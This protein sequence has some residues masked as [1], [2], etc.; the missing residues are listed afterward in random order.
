MRKG[1]FLKILVLQS[2]DKKP[3][4]SIW[5]EVWDSEVQVP[6]FLSPKKQWYLTQQIKMY[7]FLLWHI[8]VLI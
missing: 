8:F 6:G 1:N 3:G 4:Q 2:S 5:M 7:V